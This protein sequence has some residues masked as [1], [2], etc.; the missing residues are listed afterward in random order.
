M[1]EIVTPGAS[2]GVPEA[3]PN[4]PTVLRVDWTGFGYVEV[5]DRLEVFADGR[6]EHR[7]NVALF[8]LPEGSGGL[9]GTTLV[10][11]ELPE[12]TELIRRAAAEPLLA[13]SGPPSL[14]IMATW[15]IDGESGS[16]DL[17]VV[18]PG[19]DA[20]GG[21]RASLAMRADELAQRCTEAIAAVACEWSIPGSPVSGETATVYLT[22]RSVGRRPITLQLEPSALE[23]VAERDGGLVTVWRAADGQVTDLLDPEGRLLALSGYPVELSPGA[24]GGAVVDGVLNIDAG[25]WRIGPKFDLQLRTEAGAPAVLLRETPTRVMGPFVELH[26]GGRS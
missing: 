1:T 20:G 19:T 13:A 15:T 24:S 17:P 12:L 10:G 18:Q 4:E 5:R 26:V 6:V 11:D 7:P 16:I 9:F 3:V 22:L 23:L 2:P 21:A 8:R 14:G 25:S